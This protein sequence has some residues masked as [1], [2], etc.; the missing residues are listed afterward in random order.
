M[1]NRLL[2]AIMYSDKAIY[3]NLK[4]LLVEKYKEIQKESQEYDFNKF[5]SYYEKEM[6]K[7]LVKRFLIFNYNLEKKD[8]IKI[9]EQTY[10]H[11]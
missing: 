3:E 10:T 8:L 9:K 11:T 4:P 2:I 6:G 1:Q 5:T 7:G